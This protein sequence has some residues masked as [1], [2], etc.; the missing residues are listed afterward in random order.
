MDAEEQQAGE[1]E[2]KHGHG[3][4]NDGSAADM[5]LNVFNV[6]IATDNTPHERRHVSLFAVFR[7]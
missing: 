1:R 5:G 3:L 4:S 7:T 2:R 6:N